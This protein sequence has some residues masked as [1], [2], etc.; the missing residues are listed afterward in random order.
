[1]VWNGNNALDKLQGRFAATFSKGMCFGIFEVPAPIHSYNGRLVRCPRR[2][3]GGNYYIVNMPVRLTVWRTNLVLASSWFDLKMAISRLG[4]EQR[5]STLFEQLPD[6][7]IV[8]SA[9]ACVISLSERN[10][11]KYNLLCCLL[12]PEN[13]ICLSLDWQQ[14]F[15][16]FNNSAH[17]PHHVFG[18]LASCCCLVG[19]MPLITIKKQ[20]DPLVSRTF[21]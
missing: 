7:T 11:A 17:G 1:M 4:S 16:Y 19:V 15:S 13:F 5:T 21:W 8:V 9:D 14:D 18:A 10:H 3:Y 12:V 2:S 6:T 20:I